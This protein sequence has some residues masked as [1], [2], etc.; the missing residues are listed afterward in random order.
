MAFGAPGPV[1][2]PGSRSAL[3]PGGAPV[4]ADRDDRERVAL[5]D[6]AV[7]A[8]RVMGIIGGVD[9]FV[10]GNVLQEVRQDGAVSVS[11]GGISTVR[12][13]EVVVSM[14]KCTLRHWRRP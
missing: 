14:A 6:R 2:D 11:A 10:F 5:E 13:S 9:V 8:V 12:I 3:S 1:S 4:P 7:A